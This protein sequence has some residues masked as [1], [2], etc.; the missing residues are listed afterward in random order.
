MIP[1]FKFCLTHPHAAWDIF[2]LAVTSAL[3]Q[4][5]IYYSI[6][7]FGSLNT[8]IITTSRKFFTI[9]AS[10]FWFGHSMSVR[11]QMA[12]AIVFVGLSADLYAS[13]K[14]RDAK[15]AAPHPPKVSHEQNNKKKD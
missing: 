2:V 1:A 13:K 15:L 6:A 14:S 11:Q 10:C 12:V 9:L 3:G 5:F 8:S 4:N 7:E